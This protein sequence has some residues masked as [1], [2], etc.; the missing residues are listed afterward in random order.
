MLPLPDAFIDGKVG[1]PPRQTAQAMTP[2][3]QD[4]PCRAWASPGAISP[5]SWPWGHTRP[6]P[7]WSL[8]RPVR[9]DGFGSRPGN[10]WSP[11]HWDCWAEG[12]HLSQDTS[13][14]FP[15]DSSGLAALGL[16]LNPRAGRPLVPVVWEGGHQLRLT[17]CGAQRGVSRAQSFPVLP[18]P[19]MG[20]TYAR[21]SP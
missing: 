5:L 21:A 6:V 18:C 8:P 13:C 12:I 14:L 4:R 16:A 3:G 20:D 19:R 11:W 10:G 7:D 17:G 15:W 1:V 2:M 9:G